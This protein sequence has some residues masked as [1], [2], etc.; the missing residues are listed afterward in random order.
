MDDTLYIQFTPGY[1]NRG[2]I[3]ATSYR[4]ATKVVK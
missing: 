2:D 3:H 1:Y 4:N